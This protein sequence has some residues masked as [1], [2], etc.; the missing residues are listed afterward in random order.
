[1]TGPTSDEGRMR[2]RMDGDY[3]AP[4]VREPDA[5]RPVPTWSGDD[6]PPA[7]ERPRREGGRS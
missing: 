4:I 3:E 2:E 6:D 7:D 1:M 5:D